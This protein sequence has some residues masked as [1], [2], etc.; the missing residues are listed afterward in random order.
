M[1]AEGTD[2]HATLLVADFMARGCRQQG[3]GTAAGAKG[4]R[5]AT[6]GSIRISDVV[7]FLR[8]AK[9]RYGRYWR[10]SARIAGAEAELAETAIQRLEKL[11]LIERRGDSVS[12]LPA[13][14]R[15]ALGDADIRGP[16][17]RAAYSLPAAA[18]LELT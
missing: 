17:E 4:H 16:A 2:A 12:P 11:H 6:A 7:D 14:A 3:P 15:F 9:G 1:P 5:E 10:K 13:L 8:A 18:E